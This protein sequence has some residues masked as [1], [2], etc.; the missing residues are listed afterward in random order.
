MMGLADDPQN[1]LMMLMLVILLVVEDVFSIERLGN[2]LGCTYSNVT[3]A[4]PSSWLHDNSLS[5][6]AEL[7]T[8]FAMRK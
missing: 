2:N 5:M 8:D 6:I 3:L 7:M 4:H 1:S